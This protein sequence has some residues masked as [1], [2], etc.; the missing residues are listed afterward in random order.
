M[1]SRLPLPAIEAFNPEQR[2]IFDAIM[3][4]R[5]SID[6]PFLAWLHSPKLADA[7]QNLGA[8]CRFG[9]SLDAAE[10]ELLILL[11]AAHYDCL[12]E[13]QIHEPIAL[14]SGLPLAAVE[15]IRARLVPLLDGERLRLL[16]ELGAQLLRQSTP[17]QRC[18]VGFPGYR[19][20]T[21]KTFPTATDLACGSPARLL[22]SDAWTSR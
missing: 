14:A 3:S 9:S 8:F 17:C 1:K 4:T 7:A 11:V 22:P 2:G 10:S 18:R 21:C 5:G 12:A 13:Q 20:P 15:A 16:L 6:G 19:N